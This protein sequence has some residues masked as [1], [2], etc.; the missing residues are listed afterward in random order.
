MAQQAVINAQENLRVMTGK[1]YDSLNAPREN[2]PLAVPAP[3]DI[4]GW[5]EIA[6]QNNKGLQA[7]KQAIEVARQTIEVE[8]AASK[9]VVNLYAQH[10][11]N[12]N[13]S[14][15]PL[16]PITVGA[17]L[18]WKPA[19]RCIRGARSTPESVRPSIIFARPS[20]TTTI[21]NA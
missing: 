1:L 3:G 13:I 7:A 14:E 19:C 9:P 5:V 6:K 16:D 11:G 12:L 4:R 21:R 20:K 15:A 2:F 10:T 17:R 18:G 8:R